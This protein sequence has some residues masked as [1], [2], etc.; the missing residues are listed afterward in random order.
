MHCLLNMNKSQNQAPVAQTLDSSIHRINL[1]PTDSVIDFRNIY[2]LPG[3]WFI[4][5]GYR[6]PAFEKLGTERFLDF[7][8][9]HYYIF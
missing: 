7:G 4:R 6:Y 9:L 8:T 5:G 2:P 3:W 1:Y